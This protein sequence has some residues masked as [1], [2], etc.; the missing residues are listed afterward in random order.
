LSGN[1]ASQIFTGVKNPFFTGLQFTAA[2][3]ILQRELTILTEAQV[4][5]IKFLTTWW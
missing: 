5:A 2:A 1:S 4:Y 3:G